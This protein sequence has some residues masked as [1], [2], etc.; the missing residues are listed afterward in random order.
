MNEPL[1]RLA[2]RI[3][4]EC[5]ELDRVVQRV[6]EGWQRAQQTQDDFYVDSNSFVRDH[7]YD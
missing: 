4:G 2:E 6:R 3:R 5:T 1:L 7:E